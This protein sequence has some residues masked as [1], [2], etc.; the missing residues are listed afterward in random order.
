M[1]EP[2][3]TEF[4]EKCKEFQ[5][6]KQHEIN[7]MDKEANEYLKSQIQAMSACLF[8]PDYLLDEAWSDT[9]K[10]TS[11]AMEE[12]NPAPLYM[13]QMLRIFPRE[14]AVKLKM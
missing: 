12:Y 4:V 14:Y 5:Q 6:F 10:L 3:K 9:G 7:Q 13:E 1:P 8:L 2:V 11:E